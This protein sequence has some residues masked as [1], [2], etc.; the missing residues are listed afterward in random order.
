MTNKPLKDPQPKVDQAPASDATLT[1]INEVVKEAPATEA[2]VTSL[3][4]RRKPAGKPSV[5]KQL[6]GPRI[7]KG[8]RISKPT[9]GTV[10]STYN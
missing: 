8:K 4:P 6:K 5:K 1:S 7:G 10:T 9:F 2:T 3:T